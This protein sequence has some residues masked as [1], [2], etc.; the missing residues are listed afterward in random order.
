MADLQEAARILVD[1]P[2]RPPNTLASLHDRIAA[3]HRRRRARVAGLAVLVLVGAG[4][5]ITVARNSHQSSNLAVHVVAPV[6]RP[7]TTLPAR[8]PVDSTHERVNFGNASIVVPKNWTVSGPGTSWCYPS[9]VIALGKLGPSPVCP[10]PGPD[11][12]TS[13]VHLTTWTNNDRATALTPDAPSITINDHRAIQLRDD[14][15]ELSLLAAGS[16]PTAGS[17][18]VPDLGIVIDYGGI[19]SQAILDSLDWSDRHVALT[20]ASANANVAI[21]GWTAMRFGGVQF[22]VPAG[23][24]TQ[25][26]YGNQAPPDICG[27]DPLIEGVVTEGAGSSKGGDVA[28]PMIPAYGPG[29]SIPVTAGIDGVWVRPVDEQHLGTPRLTESALAGVASGHATVV[30]NSGSK[31]GAYAPPYVVIDVDTGHDIHIWFTIGLG[32][33]PT[34][35]G[36]IIA[37]LQVY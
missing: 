20:Y 12:V 32:P 2:T 21:P 25:T 8:P 36:R 33:D 13:L 24:S 28:C 35:A 37:S 1:Q 17:Y 34:V 16:I 4:A 9:R 18:V 14:S 27:T 11:V 15:T 6:A 29:A 23:F 7:P 3:R 31:S 19:G 22:N 10:A 30:E 5:G 26:V